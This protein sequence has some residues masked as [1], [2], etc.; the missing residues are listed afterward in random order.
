MFQDAGRRARDLILTHLPD[1][2]GELASL[3]SVGRGELSEEALED[4]RLSGVS[5]II[6][7]SGLHMVILSQA[8]LSLL[9]K[10]RLPSRLASLLAILGVGGYTVLVGF[11]LRW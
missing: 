1:D 8:V 5:H 9:K 2:R 4:F 7:V 10:C 3:I 11:A 6:A